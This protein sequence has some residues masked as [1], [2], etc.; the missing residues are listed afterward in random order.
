MWNRCRCSCV[1]E[2]RRLRAALLGAVLLASAC[3]EPAP[4]HI[5]FGLPT[6]PLTLDPRYAT[7]ATSERLVHLVHRSLVGFD[8]ASAPVPDLARWSAVGPR[9]YRFELEPDA[10]FSDGRAI[11]AA[12][13]VATYRSVL[14]RANAS[15]HRDALGN[16]AAVRAAGPRAVEFELHREDFMF[17]GTL[18]I[19]ILPAEAASGP[20]RDRFVASSGAFERLR[21][22]ADG[23]V[24]LRRRRDGMLFE[25]VPVPDVSVR[26]LKLLG[27]E[28]DIIQGS[29]T[30]EIFAWLGR[31]PGLAAERVPGTTFSY[32][33]FNLAAGRTA[34]RRLRLAIAHAIDREAI[35]THLFGG[36]ARP[37]AGLFPPEHWAGAPG[38]RAPRYDPAA[39][40]AL[41]D[42][43]GYATPVRL[44]YKT[45]ADPFRRRLAL[46]L[47][48]QLLAVG[49][50]LD[51]ESHDWGTFYGDVRAGRFELYALSWVGLR[52]PDILRNV[53]HSSATPPGGANRGRYRSAAADALIEQ[54]E[55]AFTRA[56]R[57]RA[58][59][60]LTERLLYDLPY[61][62]LWYEDHLVVRRD[63]IAGYTT[64][65][66]GR[67]DALELTHRRATLA[68]P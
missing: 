36:A 56:A 1:P 18:G 8:E 61:V 37:A 41:I 51:I 45:S 35:I 15:P 5:R 63:D 2:R 27:G 34:E 66:D 33:G 30:P 20:A 16:I 40:R 49:I 4:T 7:D 19:G 57:Q 3:G 28:L 54:A 25:F 50:E 29:L 24:L 38:L 67:F 12:D 55:A 53:F 39:A 9:S 32:L 11:V 6:A 65:L 44:R 52:L 31:Q 10:R 48:E 59:R 62:P 68:R 23:R 47:R 13:V 60:A 43:L 22:D 17:P 46:V 42:E 21:F 26:A 58:Y 64:N 14:D